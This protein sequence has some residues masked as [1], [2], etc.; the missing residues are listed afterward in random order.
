[1]ELWLYD[2]RVGNALR[3]L[4]FDGERLIHIPP[5][6][7]SDRS[8]DMGVSD[9]QWA[10]DYQRLLWILGEMRAALAQKGYT[11][12]VADVEMALFMLGR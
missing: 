2:S 5:G 10:D 6:R 12:R 9:L 11:Y 4:A 1:M 3:D 8:S 7:V